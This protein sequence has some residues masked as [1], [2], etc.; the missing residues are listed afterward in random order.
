MII[1]INWDS[2]WMEVNTDMLIEHWNMTDI[3]T[4]L[5]LFARYGTA[6]QHDLFIQC[7]RQ[8]QTEQ[9][10]RHADLVNELAERQMRADGTIPTW[11]TQAHWQAEVKKY[12]SKVNGSNAILKRYRSIISTAKGLLT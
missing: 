9:E 5:K 8:H 10:S 1:K 12:Q 4:W 2:G 11:M 6:A 3:K 7:V